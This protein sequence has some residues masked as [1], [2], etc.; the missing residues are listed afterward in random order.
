[1]TGMT[2]RYLTFDLE[3]D[4]EFDAEVIPGD[5]E[6]AY[7]MIGLSMIVPYVELYL[8]KHSLA[9]QAIVDEPALLHDMRQFSQQ[10]SQH[11]I[12]HA[13]FNH[14]VR[15]KYPELESLEKKAQQDYQRFSERGLKFNLAFAEG[16]ESM[17]NPLVIFMWN[18]GMIR[19]M[20]G[21]LA[22]LYA[23]HF[24]EEME[25][26]TVAYDTYYHLY[27]GYW[28]RLW[29]SL[30]AQSHLLGFMF[31]CAR[32]MLRL[33][34]DRFQARGGWFG[35]LSRIWKWMRLAG[36]Y[37]IPQLWK[38]YLPGYNPRNLIVPQEVT[39]LTEQFNARAY[40]LVTGLETV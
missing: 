33:E 21:P 26:C 16:F 29:V 15:Q 27:G 28:Y 13:L 18:S 38:S 3:E 23:W 1:M 6:M 35:R 36:K 37:L 17:T 11:H 30:I 24:L 25:H 20:R 7:L 22:E 12:Q 14:R 4:K 32:L 40:K 31:A 34:R 2:V 39:N 19:D 10:E 5:V 8:V 9:A